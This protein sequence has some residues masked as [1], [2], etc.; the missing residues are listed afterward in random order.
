MKDYI[1]YGYIT[2]DTK[3]PWD[4]ENLYKGMFKK[5]KSYINGS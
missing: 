3:I 5:N 2:N 1:N 4:F